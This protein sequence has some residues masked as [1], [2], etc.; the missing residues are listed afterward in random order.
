MIAFSWLRKQ[1]QGKNKI[2][3]NVHNTPLPYEYMRRCKKYDQSTFEVL[4]HQEGENKEEGKVGS[5]K[6]YQ[7]K[8][9]L[10]IQYKEKIS[11]R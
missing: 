9:M 8:K 7:G 3:K 4:I 2:I 1:V 11:M 5:S 6:V 10:L